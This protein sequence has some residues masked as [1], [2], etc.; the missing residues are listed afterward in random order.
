MIQCFPVWVFRPEPKRERMG[1]SQVFTVRVFQIEKVGGNANRGVRNSHFHSVSK[2]LSLSLFN[3][4]RMFWSS[5]ERE[6]KGERKTYNPCF[7]TKVVFCCVLS[8][9]DFGVHSSW[10]VENI[11]FLNTKPPSSETHFLS[12]FNISLHLSHWGFTNFYFF[13]SFPLCFY[14]VSFFFETK[15]QKKRER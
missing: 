2:I 1:S 4:W 3:V 10:F 9:P 8:V 5:Q 13:F 11:L 7:W 12:P 6:R 14:F 15:T